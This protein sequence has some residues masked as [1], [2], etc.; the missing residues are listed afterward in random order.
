M[1]A[2]KLCFVFYGEPVA[3]GRPRFTT[4][5]GYARAYDPEKSRKY[6]EQI[7]REAV[8]Q[9][10]GRPPLEGAL[11]MRVR[12]YRS[13]PSAFS[14]K[15]VELAE[16]GLLRPTTRPDMDNYLKGVK[17]ALN[18]VCWKDDSQIVAYAEPFGK[19]YGK[20]PRVELEV[21]EVEG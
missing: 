12:I 10:A 7:K 20:Y 17:D 3:Q 4:G 16:N 8:E 18:G 1:M 5:C 21:W 11:V 13:M 2:N 9:M 19:Y 14:R 15:K 6:K